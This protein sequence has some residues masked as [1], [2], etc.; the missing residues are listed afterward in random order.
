MN[1]FY[2]PPFKP[3]K[4]SVEIRKIFQYACMKLISTEMPAPSSLPPSLTASDDPFTALVSQIEATIAWIRRQPEPSEPL[5]DVFARMRRRLRQARRFDA[6]NSTQNRLGMLH[7][8]NEL[9]LHLPFPQIALTFEHQRGLHC[10]L[11]EEMTGA[12]SAE[13]LCA[14]GLDALPLF[15]DGAIWMQGFSRDIGSASWLP[16]QVG[17]LVSR[18]WRH[19]SDQDRTLT[20]NAIPI[21][22]FVNGNVPPP[23]EKEE[24]TRAYAYLKGLLEF[25][26][27]LAEED[28]RQDLRARPS[29]KRAVASASEQQAGGLPSSKPRRAEYEHASIIKLGAP[30]YRKPPVAHP[31]LRHGPCEHY[32]RGHWRRIRKNRTVWVRTCLVGVRDG[33]L[34][35]VPGLKKHYILK[36]FS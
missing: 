3:S 25:C 6:G 5:F 19:R 18:H 30:R 22:V 17:L 8:L 28:L 32:R 24:R 35:E 21:P 10:V 14:N 34:K 7:Y 36:S 27:A 15:N 2:L 1:E 26:D 9:P 23:Q 12:A 20:L 4:I 29:T 13:W 16:G 11:A 31:G 33:A